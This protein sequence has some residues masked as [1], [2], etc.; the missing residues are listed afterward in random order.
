LKHQGF[1]VDL[2]QSADATTSR[3][4]DFSVSRGGEQ[5]F[6][7]EST[8]AA[9]TLMD[10]ASRKR[11]DEFLERISSLESV[12]YGLTVDYDEGSKTRGC[13]KYFEP[14]CKLD[15]TLAPD[16]AKQRSGESN[17]GML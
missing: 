11:V 5:L 3:L 2:H 14:T 7:L 13:I 15:C 16:A 8:L 6:Y 1:E 4:P 12:H 17:C 10:E 9:D